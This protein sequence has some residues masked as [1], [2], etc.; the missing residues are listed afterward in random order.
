MVICW[1]TITNGVKLIII[2]ID[3]STDHPFLN[4]MIMTLCKHRVTQVALKGGCRNNFTPSW[5]QLDIIYGGK[6]GETGTFGPKNVMV[7]IFEASK[8]LRSC[9]PGVGG[10]LWPQKP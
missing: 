5:I 10:T 1:V 9:F 7:G 2:I 8:S 6:I 3:I 4:I